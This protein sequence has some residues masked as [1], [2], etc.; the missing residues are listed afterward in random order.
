MR[1][2]AT[3]QLVAGVAVLALGATLTVRGITDSAASPGV[4]PTEQLTA[5]GEAPGTPAA[6]STPAG[7]PPTASPEPAP[8]PPV[9]VSRPALQ[10]RLWEL[11]TSPSFAMTGA[12]VGVAVRDEHGRAVVDVASDEPLLPASTM[13]LV[14]AASSLL[15]FGSGHRFETIAG[16]TQPVTV[17]GAV[18]GDLVLVGSGDPVLGT[19]LY[20]QWIYPA[21]PRTELEDLADAVVASGVRRI[22]GGV[23]GDGTAFV[24]GSV[25]RGWPEHYLWELDARHISGL[26]VDGGLGYGVDEFADP[27]QVTIE[28]TEE[29]ARLAAAALAR[30]LVERGITIERGSRATS[31]ASDIVEVVGRVESPPLAD[32][33]QHM[34]ERSDNQVADTLFQTAGVARAGTGSW[35]MGELAARAALAG[36]GVS[37]PGLVF[38]DGSGLSRDDR[39]TA[40]FLADL[41][42]AMG[43]SPH[44]A[45]WQESLAAVGQEGTLRN[46]LRGTIAEGRFLG[47]TGTLD[48]VKAVAGVVLGPDARRYH[49]A[50]IAN[51]ASG[52]D[53]TRVAVLM[54]E[55]VLA[56]VEDLDGCTRRPLELPSPTPA[57]TAPAPVQVPP[58]RLDCPAA[59]DGG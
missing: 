7:P 17:N 51:D 12:T 33:L 48:D 30:M 47:K 53:R 23:V 52:A 42:A 59:A 1:P 50:V 56:L 20:E 22:T 57:P 11:L 10:T 28:L 26:T 39:L 16:V 8:E 13:K 2:A 29:P 55:L 27:P 35:T 15:T 9:P 5:V 40:A 25:A 32:I 46:R 45:V 54:D 18:V 37:A 3:L 44:A 31:E 34:V 6:T 49:L 14:T 4:A 19:P 21:R 24:A 38:A 43:S 36:V 41:D 58:Y